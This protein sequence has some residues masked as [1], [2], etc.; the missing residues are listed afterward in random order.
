M[1]TMTGLP[2][3]WLAVNVVGMPATPFSTAKPASARIFW[4]SGGWGS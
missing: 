3:P 2:L 1:T 4:G